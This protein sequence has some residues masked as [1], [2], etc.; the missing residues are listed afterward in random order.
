MKRLTS[1]LLAISLLLL[2][3]V[4]ALAADTASTVRLESATGTVTVTGP[5][6]KSVRLQ[7]KMRLNDG[8]TVATG[9]KSYAYISLDDSKIMKLDAS[10]KATV[11]KSGKKLE[12][13]LVSGSLYFHVNKALGSQESMNIRTSTMVTGIRGTTAY[14]TAEDRL[15]SSISMLEGVAAVTSVD[16]ATGET[17]TVEV[18]GGE[19][20]YT[21]PVGTENVELTKKMLEEQSVP[22]FAAVE[23]AADPAV[24][25]RITENSPLSVPLIIGDADARLAGDEADAEKKARTAEELV[26]AQ[27]TVAVDPVFERKQESHTYS[28]G[29]GK[30]TVTHQITLPGGVGYTVYAPSYVVEDGKDFSFTVTPETGY[31]IRAVA[32]ADGTLLT[33]GEDLVTYTLRNVTADQTVTVT[34][35]KSQYSLS[36]DGGKAFGY[37]VDCPASAAPGDPVTVTL[38]LEENLAPAL[39]VLDAALLCNG[40]VSES[41]LQWDEESRPCF[42]FTMPEADCALALSGLA[43]SMS[44][45]T[46]RPE[47]GMD[48]GGATGAMVAGALNDPAVATVSVLNWQEL[49]TSEMPV[50]GLDTGTTVH[51]GQTLELYGMTAVTAAVTVETDAA[52]YY[53]LL[54]ITYPGSV[55]NSGAIE[56]LE[57]T[58]GTLTITGDGWFSNM[59]DGVLTADYIVCQH[60]VDGGRRP[61]APVQK[62]R[63]QGMVET[64]SLMAMEYSALSNEG[65]M[66]LGVESAEEPG[67]CSIGQNCMLSNYGKLI[68]T[69]QTDITGT[70]KNFTDGAIQTKQA[71]MFEGTGALELSGGE[72]TL[73]NTEVPVDTVDPDADTAAV[74]CVGAKVNISGGRIN[75]LLA[76]VA[77]APHADGYVAQVTLSGGELAISAAGTVLFDT[78]YGKLPPYFTYTG[79]KLFF[80]ERGAGINLPDWHTEPSADRTYYTLVYAPS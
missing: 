59:P 72:L 77:I 28:G 47:E 16:P 13:L 40:E 4:P 48:R 53:D 23:I 55:E 64:N 46:I 12:I 3:A 67:V 31:T 11:A 58:E 51:S 30:T 29:G 20:A 17:H 52:V 33:P 27:T 62:L 26:K 65:T 24:Q 60:V 9:A 57:G 2:T 14:V 80:P 78:S 68:C 8:Y 37:S 36:F 50:H 25:Q 63:N 75:G 45:D 32:L 21:Q 39:D 38:L 54:A 49:Y 74:Y 6:G 43:W 7:E 70:L 42:T 10:S 56:A 79:G 73:T 15:R 1:L 69:A 61:S 19:V 76:A 71:L 22:G 44:D 5:A 34:A 18:R 66:F 35:A 41:E